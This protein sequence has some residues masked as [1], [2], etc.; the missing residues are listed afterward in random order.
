M[1]DHAYYYSG[2]LGNKLDDRGNKVS[3]CVWAPTAQHVQLLLW[4]GPH[5]GTPQEVGM[6]EGSHGEW[7]CQVKQLQLLRAD[8]E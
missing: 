7:S 8:C 1:L 4:E 6:A 2:P 5:G 3:I